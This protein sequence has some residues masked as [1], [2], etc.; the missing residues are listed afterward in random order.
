MNPWVQKWPFS[1]SVHCVCVGFFFV[2]TIHVSLALS[3][4]HLLPTRVSSLWFTKSHLFVLVFHVA[5]VGKSVSSSIS[6]PKMCLTWFNDTA[7]RICSSFTWKCK[8]NE[9]VLFYLPKQKAD[10]T[11]RHIC[12]VKTTKTKAKC[13]TF[14]SHFYFRRHFI[15]TKIL[16]MMFYVFFPPKY[17]VKA[18]M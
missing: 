12:K 3:E 4:N 15:W 9:N 5:S 17:F 6:S 14:L 13:S 16:Q 7:W 2:S 1:S 10:K 8:A 18:D 11:V